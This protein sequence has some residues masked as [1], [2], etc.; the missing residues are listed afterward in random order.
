MYVVT[1]GE[2]RTAI[3]I[4]IEIATVEDPEV[5]IDT[6]A[7]EGAGT[8]MVA[9]LTEIGAETAAEADRCPAP[10]RRLGIAK[11]RSP[12]P[13]PQLQFFHILRY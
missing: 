12:R 10:D 4:E 2:T 5:V 3:E 7:V 1:E 13:Y 11:G 9:A 6:A 8:S